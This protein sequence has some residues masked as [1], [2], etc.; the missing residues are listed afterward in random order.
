MYL[1][2]RLCELRGA[3]SMPDPADLA[4]R[5]GPHALIF[6]AVGHACFRSTEWHLYGHDLCAPLRITGKQLRIGETIRVFGQAGGQ[7]VFVCGPEGMQQLWVITI[8][9][10]ASCERLADTCTT[11][12]SPRCSPAECGRREASAG[13]W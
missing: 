7:V 9:F 2:F 13:S 12:V 1:D 3:I 4:C 10:C 6:E 11:A 5:R 8:R